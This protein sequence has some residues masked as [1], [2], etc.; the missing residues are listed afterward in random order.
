MSRGGRKE[1]LLC[2]GLVGWGKKKKEKRKEGERN[3]VGCGVKKR[4][5]KRKGGWA[6]L[7]VGCR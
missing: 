3:G 1:V 5:K 7:G 2:R 6:R 4:E